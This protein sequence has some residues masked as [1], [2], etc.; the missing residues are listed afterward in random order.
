MHNTFYILSFIHLP[1]FVLRKQVE[2]T[3]LSSSRCLSLSAHQCYSFIQRKQ[4][5]YISYR[6]MCSS[7]CVGSIISVV[8]ISDGRE[9][10][11]LL[12]IL[13]QACHPPL[14]PTDKRTTRRNSS[15]HQLCQSYLK[16]STYITIIFLCARRAGGRAGGH[17]FHLSVH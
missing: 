7:E 12:P 17:R 13:I 4:S 15:T 14:P 1:R 11:R 3:H 6:N 5:C 16:Q 2:A 9:W 8:N 10:E